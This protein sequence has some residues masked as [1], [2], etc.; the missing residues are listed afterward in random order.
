MWLCSLA[1][2]G[3]HSVHF[4]ADYGVDLG[5]G[6]DVI[7]EISPQSVATEHPYARTA[8]TLAARDCSRAKDRWTPRQERV[9]LYTRCLCTL[10][11]YSCQLMSLADIA[12]CSLWMTE[13][14]VANV[15]AVFWGTERA[16]E[17]RL[18]VHGLFGQIF[19]P[20]MAGIRVD[21][22]PIGMQP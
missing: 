9:Q 6:D 18:L 21:P 7:G 19:L 20:K 4:G 1:A 14:K 5:A 16:R 3:R 17:C 13:A 22:G 8:I 15:I 10:V 12:S 2:S 11:L